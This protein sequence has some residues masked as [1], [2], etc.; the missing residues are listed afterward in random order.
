MAADQGI[1]DSVSNADTKTVA[2]M[3]AWATAQR[4][5]SEVTHAQRLNQIAEGAMQGYAAGMTA[6]IKRMTELDVQ[7]SA[8]EADIRQSRLSEQ[9][10]SLGTA[11]AALQQAIKGAQTTPPPTA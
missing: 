7:E 6:L 5:A 8:S 9:I 11:V 3:S 10:A 1:V 4:M 2:E